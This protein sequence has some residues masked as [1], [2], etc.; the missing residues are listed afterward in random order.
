MEIANCFVAL[1]GDKGNAVPV[2]S[3]TPAQ[4]TILQ[5][6]HGDDAVFDILPIE[7][8]TDGQKRI[9]A[10]TPKAERTR[11]AEF[12][13]AKTPEG[14]S[15][16]MATYPGSF[17]DMPMT[18][19]QL[20]LDDSFYRAT[21]R[22][23]PKSHVEAAAAPEASASASIED[24]VP[25]KRGRRGKKDAAPQAVPVETPAAETLADEENESDEDLAPE[26][27]D[28]DPTDGVGIFD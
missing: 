27:G 28:A 18:F 21:A 9:A 1:G 2:Y 25:L 14:G 16:V 26:P 3:V 5:A 15:V 13:K 10:G 7:P 19:E 20:D 11:L 22:A 6:I 24:V 12:Y 23:R 17:P 8:S 4:V